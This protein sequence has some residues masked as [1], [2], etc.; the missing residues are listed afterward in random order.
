MSF[1]RDT[2]IS[3]KILI[4]PIIMITAL[5][6]VLLLAIHGF[7]K[8]RSIFDEVYDIALERATLVNE[9]ISLS[10]SVQSSFLRIGVANYMNLSEKE[11]LPVYDHLEQGL[12]D[13]KVI[14]GHILD[15]WP[16]DQEEKAILEKMK[17]PMDAFTRQAQQATAVI[18]KSPSFGI[19][20]A[21][22]AA[23]PFADF[24]ALLTEF[25]NGQK[26][27][28]IHAETISKRAAKTVKTTTAAI[29][30][31]M[32]LI[33]ILSTVWIA[34][35]LIS[36]PV[37]SITDVMEQL[38]GGD[39][40]VEV[41]DLRRKDEIGSMARAV[42]VFRENAIEKRAAEEALRREKDFVDS[43]IQTA[44]AVVLIIDTKGNIVSFNPYMQEIS[45]YPLKE[46]QGK[47]WFSTFLPERDRNRIKEMFLHAIAGIQ[48]RGNVNPIV[49]KDGR[50]LQIEW[51]DKTLK[52]P[53]G[54]V[55]G[56]LAIG[57][58]ITERKQTEAERE[59][60]VGELQKAFSEI[61]TLKGILPICAS[62]KRI[63]DDKGYW[64]QI[65]AYIRDRSDAQFSHGICPECR[66]KLYPEFDKG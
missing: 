24:R 1:F 27:K 44:Q 51:Y 52:D 22:S 50:E 32:A 14:Y 16:L 21:R 41:A 37:R 7:D 30:I 23:V 28:I 58:D 11:I 26:K 13:M 35:R 49:T 39:L 47:D 9:F 54:R 34:T 17:I 46:V 33:A 60:L 53:E 8:Q 61:K 38:A 25:L 15:K 63:R 48:T 6:V 59:K 42:E 40:S 43:I 18:S 20:I 12:S 45:G 62:C 5:G 36:H 57:Q 66:E 4:P 56:L 19:L 55:V 64:N 10:E 29:A 2:S 65:E 31:F 3:N